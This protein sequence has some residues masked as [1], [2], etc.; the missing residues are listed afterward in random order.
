M[1]REA[2]AALGMIPES[3]P[4]VG[5]VS[6]TSVQSNNIADQ[7]TSG[8]EGMAGSA[9]PAEEDVPLFYKNMTECGESDVD[10]RPRAECGCLKRTAPPPL[11]VKP[12]FTATDE[13]RLR[14]ENFIREYYASSGFNTCP[15]Q[16]LPAMSGPPMRL[17]IDP[18]Q[19]LLL[20]TRLFQSHFTGKQIQKKILTGTFVWTYGN[21]YLSVSM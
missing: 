5:G 2:C 6:S 3:F 11:P 21:G 4:T 10:D 1:S 17:K 19:N 14:L 15:H 13:N 12:P 7:N 8:Y 18:L 16:T 9:S 20:F